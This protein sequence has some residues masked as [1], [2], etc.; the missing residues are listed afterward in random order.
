MA[1]HAIPRET[2]SPPKNG[3]HFDFVIMGGG[4]A[5]NVIAGRLAENPNVSILILEAGIADSINNEDIRTPAVAMNLR[6]GQHDW[7]YLAK[8]V[9]RPEYSKIE[10]EDTRGRALGGSSSLNYFTWLSGCR[11]TFDEWEE[12]GGSD[13]NWNKL[14]P[15]LQKSVTY[16]DD[17]GLY[18]KDFAQKI[19]TKGPLPISHA[20][21]VKESAP[22][23]EKL[24]TAW[25]NTGREITENVFEGQLSGMTH[26]VAT[27]YHGRRSGSFLFTHDKP[28]VTIVGNVRSKKI[29]IE[30]A[31]KVAKGVTVIDGHG[32]ELS[33]FADREVI[34]SQGVFE[35]P[36]LLMLSGIGP[37]DQLKKFNIDVIQQSEHVGQHLLDHPAVPFVLKIKEGYGLDPYL[38]HQG[39]KHDDA[40]KLYHDKKGT[41]K[42]GPMGSGLLELVGFPRIDEYLERDETYRKAKAANGGKD[43]FCPKGQ[44]HFELDF[45]NLFGPAFQ[46]HYSNPIPQGEHISVVVD[47]VRPLSCLD[48]G[49]VTLRSDDPLFPPNINLNFFSND[50][51]IIGMREGVRFTYDLLTKVEGFKDIVEAEYPW[52][53]PLDDDKAMHKAI[54]DRCQTAF[55]PCGTA[56]IGKTIDQGAVDP[57]LKVHGVKN[58]RAIDASN[59]PII[60]DCR[61]QNA[62]YAV[63]ERG[64]DYIKATHKDLYK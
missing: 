31:G 64:A 16:H 18:P 11:P 59:I 50:L 53:M 49:E 55:H 2:S 46:W 43:P 39:K 54:L 63:A 35:T 48:G 10:K 36:K 45:L 29:I 28:N 6:G 15:Y 33:Y 40:V 60:P 7:Q 14:L 34:V 5:G 8:F 9:D 58:L 62:V 21:L 57:Q 30:K 22:F 13:W 42:T 61:I 17:E 52:S 32:Q 38:L 51:D 56:R 24:I 20:E 27:I 41:G 3:S 37:I 25:K 1:H 23:R 47:L 44:P 4:T 12:F 26:C 19:G